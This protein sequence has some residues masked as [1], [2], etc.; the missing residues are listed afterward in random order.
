MSISQN[1]PAVS[2]SL[3]LN[4]ARSKKLDPRIT[5]TRSSSAT[6]TNAQGLVE[7]VSANVPRFDHS[8]NS[9][10][11]S[12]NSL[13]LL[14]EE[15]RTNLTT[16]SEDYSNNSFTSDILIS[17]NTITSP[18]GATTADTL[19][20]NI[21]GGSN[22][23]LVDKN[24]VSTVS[25]DY[26]YSVF[27]KA[28]TSSKSTANLYFT[29][30]TFRQAVLE[31][32][33]GATPS[34]VLTTTG[35]TT[36]TSSLVSYPNGWYRAIITYNSGNNTGGVSRVY[37]RDQGTS[38]VSGQT[39]YAWGHQVET[40]AFPTS[41][42]PTVAST[43]TRSADNASITGTNFSS[44][45]NQ[46]EGTLFAAARINALGGSTYPGIITVDDGTGNNSIGILV[47]DV[48]GDLIAAEAYV[49]NVNQYYLSTGATTITSNQLTK[50]ITAYK[51]NDFA[52]AF[53]ITNTV[54]TDT[55]GSVPTVNRLIIGD[56][57]GSGAK[58]NGTVAQI[59]Y[60]PRRLT[61]TQLQN[62]TK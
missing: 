33:W 26:T 62:L 3:N 42:I 40:G 28:G 61:N 16:Y 49:S 13:G 52:A 45:Y 36:A 50:V 57:R 25:T 43:V 15:S 34:T 21:N 54:G 58:L 51:V 14:I 23:C 38:N 7:T 1:F 2:P 6:R 41:Y 59:L 44:F 10:T 48:T 5:F 24:F 18:D 9:S 8:Y 55:S 37:V 22:T 20:A 53:S 30:G 11:G 39:V 19:T 31:I 56:L 47:V 27:L 46:T 4:F 35:G 29:G 17:T 60:Y 32:T 12:V